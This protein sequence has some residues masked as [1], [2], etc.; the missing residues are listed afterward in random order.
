MSSQIYQFWAPVDL[1]TATGVIGAQIHS[2]DGRDCSRSELASR[3][4]RR[5][6]HV[7]Q[8]RSNDKA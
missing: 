7:R 8:F 5:L 1:T 4:E 2:M 3:A 6:A